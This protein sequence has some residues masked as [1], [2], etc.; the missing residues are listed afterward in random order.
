MAYLRARCFPKILSLS[1]L[2]R[3]HNSIILQIRNGISRPFYV[4]LFDLIIGY[5]KKNTFNLYVLWRHGMTF[6]P[7]IDVLG[8]AFLRGSNRIHHY[9]R[10]DG[11][12]FWRLRPGGD[13][14]VHCHR[15]TWASRKGKYYY[16]VRPSYANACGASCSLIKESSLAGSWWRWLKIKNKKCKITQRVSEAERHDCKQT[17]PPQRSLLL[18]EDQCCVIPTVWL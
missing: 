18:S 5:S 7:E 6:Q 4:L 17:L 10:V 13:V 9:T 15:M 1:E 14:C 3:I 8:Y 16:N 11:S 2:L 12:S